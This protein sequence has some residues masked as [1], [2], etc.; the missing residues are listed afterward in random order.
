[1]RDPGNEVDGKPRLH[2]SVN[3]LLEVWPPCCA[4]PPSSPSSSYAPVSNT[5]SHDNHEKSIH[6][7]PLLFYGMG[8]R[9]GAFDRRSF[10]KASCYDQLTPVESS[11][12]LTISI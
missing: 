9:L 7:F 4:T 6:G 1:M 3:P 5:A 12:P 10:A 2:V 8:L 11:Y